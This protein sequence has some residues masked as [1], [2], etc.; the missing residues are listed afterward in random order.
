MYMVFNKLRKEISEPLEG[1]S[2]H[3]VVSGRV[4]IDQLMI[5]TVER[6]LGWV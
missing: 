3:H 4:N 1:Y 6:T 2:D 5:S